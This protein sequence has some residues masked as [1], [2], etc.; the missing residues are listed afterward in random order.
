MLAAGLLNRFN[1]RRLCRPE[2]SGVRRC[3][4]VLVSVYVSG[5]GAGEGDG[6]DHDHGHGQLNPEAVFA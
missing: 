1:R 6:D 5:T 2:R 3:Y 4:P